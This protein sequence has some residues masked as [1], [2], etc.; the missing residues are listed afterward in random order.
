MA[1]TSSRSWGDLPTEIRLLIL[2]ALLDSGCKLA[3][4]VTVSREWQ[5]VIER[6]VFARIKLTP[7]CLADF[8]T[9]IHRNRAL[10]HYIWFCVELGE[11]DCRECDAHFETL[12]Y[13]DANLI[14]RA[15]RDL[16]WTL[17]T[18]EPNGELLLDISVYSPSDSK[19]WFK[20]L[21]F[22]PDIAWSE[23]GWSTGIEQA[24]PENID[25]DEHDWTDDSETARVRIASAITNNFA[26]IDFSSSV[27]HGQR[28]ESEWWGTLPY[29]P[30]I[31]GL[32]LRQQTRRQWSPFSLQHMFEHLSGLKEIYLEPWKQVFE[33]VTSY[34]DKSQYSLMLPI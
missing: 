14:A 8:A 19:H 11:Y 6:R 34:R 26:L 7:Y 25:D 21:T 12:S 13:V 24:L 15:I 33:D 30:A 23:C 3:H 16:F 31:T 18:W 22:R 10:L 9:N 29:V 27:F 32:I 1:P 2:E 20:Y 5:E 17:H 4:L 28:K